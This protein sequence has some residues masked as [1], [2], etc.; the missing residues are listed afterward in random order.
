MAKDKKKIS[1]LD[2]TAPLSAGELLEIAQRDENGVWKARK[3]NINQIKIFLSSSSSSSS[4]SVSS[5]S[6]SSSSSLSSSS[7]SESSSSFSSSS[8]YIWQER[9]ESPTWWTPNAPVT[10]DGVK[11]SYTSVNPVD[12]KFISTT[13]TWSIGYIPEKIRI[14]FTLTAGT[15]DFSL[16]A[17]LGQ[18]WGD[19]LNQSPSASVF[20]ISLPSPNPSLFYFFYLRFTGVDAG[21]TLE[22]IDI[23]FAPSSSSSSSSSSVSK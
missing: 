14:K 4:S 8:S 13:T 15:V 9:F 22:I 2:P 1:E 11:Y 7:S 18:L 5:S 10:W 16:E 12:V 20:D 21:E 17:P 3:V 23:E 19:T 6:S